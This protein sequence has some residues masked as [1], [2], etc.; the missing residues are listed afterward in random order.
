MFEFNFKNVLDMWIVLIVY[1]NFD[2]QVNDDDEMKLFQRTAVRSHGFLY[3][4]KSF[5]LV[6]IKTKCYYKRCG[7]T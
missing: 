1:M 4:T 3:I 7:L 2:V 5:F 6:C